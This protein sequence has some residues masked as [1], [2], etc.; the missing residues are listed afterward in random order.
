MKSP[1]ALDQRLTGIVIPSD[2]DESGNVLELTLQADDEQEY[3]LE[4]NGLVKYIQERVE[5]CGKIHCH[6]NGRKWL[7]VVRIGRV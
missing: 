2:W 5:A 1:P 7:K 3:R 4:G 6:A